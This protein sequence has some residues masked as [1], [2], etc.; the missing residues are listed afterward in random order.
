MSWWMWEVR[1]FSF[2][3]GGGGVGLFFFFFF[4][5]LVE[6]CFFAP[7][8]VQ[9]GLFFPISELVFVADGFVL[10]ELGLDKV[11]RLVFLACGG[12]GVCFVVVFFVFCVFTFGRKG[13]LFA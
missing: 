7:L 13:G 2:L 9:L 6:G 5:S 8:D 11:G 12:G 4:F 10:T 1:G 3:G